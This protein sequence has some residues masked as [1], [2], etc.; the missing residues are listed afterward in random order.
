MPVPLSIALA[1][2]HLTALSSRALRRGAGATASGRVILA[3]RP[4]ALSALSRNRRII[5]VSG[6]NGKTSTAAL[7]RELLE[8]QTEVGGNRTGANLDSGMAAALAVKPRSGLV[9]LEVDEMF[10]PRALDELTPDRLLLLNLS[11]DQLHRT[12]EVR[13]VARAW[14]SAID[15]HPEIDVVID[16]EDPFLA[17]VTRD[18]IRTDRVGFGKRQH[19]DAAS[20][21]ECGAFLDWN[22]P[23]YLCPQCGLGAATETLDLAKNS[24]GKTAVERNL[25]LA[26][27]V[28]AHYGV[29]SDDVKPRDRVVTKS[30]GE[31]ILN[32]RLVKN[33][34]SWIEALSSLPKGP[35]V[36]MVN[37]RGVDGLDTSWLWDVDYTSLRGCEVFVTGERR[38]DASYRI[39]VDGVQHRVCENLTEAAG[40]LRGPVSVLASYTA[41]ISVTSKSRS[42]STKATRL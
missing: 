15:R 40:Y 18:H 20:C 29:N 14:R 16:Y 9:V 36:L 32:I 19:L 30:I 31:A 38:L 17:Y 28:A 7:L 3:L 39:H 37:A 35:V 33:P 41:F 1:L 27:I 4:D 42:R 26:R 21:P 8:T 23:R 6:T 10:L 24:I 25:E 11:R 2:G 34:A 12:S 5:L 22:G 13:M